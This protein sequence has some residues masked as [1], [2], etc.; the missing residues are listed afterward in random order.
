M[1]VAFLHAAEVTLTQLV[2]NRGGAIEGPGSDSGRW[3]GEI[4]FRNPCSIPSAT[5]SCWPVASRTRSGPAQQPEPRA[6]PKPY[7]VFS[8]IT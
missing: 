1:D 5:L 3:T 7:P 4:L 8:L 6:H 2:S